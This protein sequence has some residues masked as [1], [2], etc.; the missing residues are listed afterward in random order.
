ME[1]Q[2]RRF[3]RMG[4]RFQQVTHRLGWTPAGRRV[5]RDRL[6]VVLL[7][8]TV[9]MGPNGVLTNLPISH[10]TPRGAL[11]SPGQPNLFDPTQGANSVLWKPPAGRSDP[12]WQPPPPQTLGHTLPPS[13]QPGTLALRPGV[14]TQFLGSD[15]RLEVDV[16]GAAVSAADLTQAGGA[17]TLQ[18]TQIAP[19]AGSSAGGSGLISF[20]TYLLQL[21]DSQRRRVPHGIRVGAG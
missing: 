9:L 3:P 21:L 12:N 18:I 19:G 16:P 17:L 6:V 2:R 10:A 13:M 11:G 4:Q 5:M 8:I 14:D 7:F 20:G 1:P 15:G